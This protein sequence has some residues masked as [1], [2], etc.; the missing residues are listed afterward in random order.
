[1][2]HVADLGPFALRDAVATCDD[3][4]RELAIGVVN[5]DRDRGHAATIDLGS[6]VAA[7]ELRVFEVNGPDVDATNSFEHPHRVAVREHRQAV[8]GH[9]LDWTFPAHSASV[10]R[11]PLAP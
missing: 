2:H 3:G 6:A 9:R 7:G 10:L 4:G 11:V 5:R 8:A 1:M